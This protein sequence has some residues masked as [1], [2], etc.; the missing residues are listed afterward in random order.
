MFAS[1]KEKRTAAAGLQ[2]PSPQ[3]E[4]RPACLLM[5]DFDLSAGGGTDGVALSPRRPVHP[6][7]LL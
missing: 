4:E 3:G 5:P 1:V 2:R 6:E 7:G